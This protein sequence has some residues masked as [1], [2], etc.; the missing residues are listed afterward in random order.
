MQQLNWWQINGFFLFCSLIHVV[1]IARST[2]IYLNSLTFVCQKQRKK[3][4]RLNTSH[5]TTH[6]QRLRN[7]FMLHSMKCWRETRK[8]THTTHINHVEAWTFALVNKRRRRYFGFSFFRTER[9]T[10]TSARSARSTSRNII[11][12]PHFM[13]KNHIY[14]RNRFSF[15]P[16][17]AGVRPTERNANK[18]ISDWKPSA[19]SA[20]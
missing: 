4:S 5:A 20:Q 3:R 8:N 6:F 10:S 17:V 18:A 9:K 1:S 19:G 14:L 2:G 7:D 15:N 11:N 13:Y 12:I 16:S